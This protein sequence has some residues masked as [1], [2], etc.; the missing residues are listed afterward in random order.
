MFKDVR[1]IDPYNKLAN[2]EHVFDEYN[3]V[4]SAWMW[5]IVIY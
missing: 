5:I 1:S 3:K 2:H 4:L